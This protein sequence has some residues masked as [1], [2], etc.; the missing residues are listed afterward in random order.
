MRIR[1][2]V[3]QDVARPTGGN[4]Y[5]RAVAA[6]LRDRGDQVELVPTSARDLGDVLAADS[7]GAN[8]CT[9]VDG[10]LASA[11]PMALA[12]SGAAV[13][14]HMPLAWREPAQVAVEAAALR[15]ASF[16]VAT[17]HWTAR[18]LTESYGIDAAVVQPGCDPAPIEAGSDPPLIV[19]VA[20]FAPHKDQLA[21]VVALAELT[22]LSWRARLAGSR[23]T[24]PA[25]AE[26]V[27]RAVSDHGLA[28]RI[29]MPG[30]LSP[31]RCFAGADI[32]LLP[33]RQEAFGMVVTEALARGIPTIVS[34]GGPEEAL[35]RTAAGDRP[36][37]VLDALTDSLGTALPRAL[38]RWLTDE[39][40]RAELRRVA[41]TRR[42]ELV[43]WGTQAAK[44]AEVLTAGMSGGY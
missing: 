43:D 42:T 17:S 27:V 6:A 40:H 33:S 19:Q 1:F 44:L 32:A 14:V 38:R 29:E 12:G 26:R 20:T 36:G 3:P 5:D 37:V 23:E 8:T 34:E 24:D 16:V 39:P 31:D 41:L 28:D 21:V 30:E 18:F 22:E 15:A 10:L 35:G 9:L 11:Q 13:V 25:Y 2:V 7:F 4:I